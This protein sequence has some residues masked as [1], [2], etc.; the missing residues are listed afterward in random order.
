MVRWIMLFITEIIKI[1]FDLETLKE[2][3]LGCV[4]LYIDIIRLCTDHFPAV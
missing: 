3:L 4:P 2:Y 1:C